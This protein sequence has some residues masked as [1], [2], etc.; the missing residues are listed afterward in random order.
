MKEELSKL[1]EEHGVSLAP[2]AG[3]DLIEAVKAELQLPQPMCEFYSISNGLQHDWFRIPPL[4]DPARMKQTWDSLQRLNDLA[5]SRY[6]PG[7]EEFL[8]D[9]LVCA[10]LAGPDF[11]VLKREDGTIWFSQGEQLHQTDMNLIEL[12]AACLREVDQL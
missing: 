3:R 12:I 5:H 8:K 7:E 4:H 10:E 6:L 9:F 11:A 2:P 1:A